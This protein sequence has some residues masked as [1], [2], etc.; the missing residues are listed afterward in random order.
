MYLII[1]LFFFIFQ[2][3]HNKV[4]A[5]STEESTRKSIFSTNLKKI[6][7]HNREADNGVHTYRLGVNKFADLVSIQINHLLLIV[8]TKRDFCNHCL[9]RRG[10][11]SYSTWL[12]I[13][14][15]KARSSY[16]QRQLYPICS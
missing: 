13:D 3:K 2:A 16:S 14:P 5:S 7:A 15:P 1:I 10:I 8:Y 6:N 4:Y 12:Q 11:Q 9:D